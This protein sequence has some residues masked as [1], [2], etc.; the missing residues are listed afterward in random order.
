M[1]NPRALYEICLEAIAA[2]KN[3][4]IF[5][6]PPALRADVW[7]RR[8]LARSM[9]RIESPRPEPDYVYY[10]TMCFAVGAA[11]ACVPF[12]TVLVFVWLTA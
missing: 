4:D 9:R 7:E 8:M 6:L 12:G 1:N 3:L 5:L 2:D 10:E 11:L